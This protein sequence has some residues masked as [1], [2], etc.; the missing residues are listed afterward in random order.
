ME[1][2]IGL[3]QNVKKEIKIAQLNVKAEKKRKKKN[4]FSSSS[5]V[6]TETE[7]SISSQQSNNEQPKQYP[8]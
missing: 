6:E 8:K 2:A 7:L 4:F 3:L 5:G 1:I